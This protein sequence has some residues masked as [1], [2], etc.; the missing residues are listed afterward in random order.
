M[1]SDLM[2]RAS[3]A[4]GHAFRVVGWQGDIRAWVATERTPEHTRYSVLV[5]YADC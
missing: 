4:S 5:R 1:S 2:E 3:G